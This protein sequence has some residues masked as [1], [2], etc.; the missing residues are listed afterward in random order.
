MQLSAEILIVKRVA[1][2]L[3]VVF[4]ISAFCLVVD[5]STLLWP[6][7]KKVDF[8][9][10]PLPGLCYNAWEK[11]C[12]FILNGIINGFVIVDDDAQVSP[13]QLP[14]HPSTKLQSDLY[15]KATEQVLNEIRCGNYVLCDPPPDSPMTAIHKPDG[16]LRLIYGCSTLHGSSVNN[17]CSSEWH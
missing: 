16:G 4:L 1:L 2:S 14:N 3:N 13:V 7:W 12:D 15:D 5:R 17:Y 8:E 11:D 10:K 6:M 9:V